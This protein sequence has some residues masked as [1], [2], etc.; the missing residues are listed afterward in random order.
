M[1]SGVNGELA[2]ADVDSAENVDV[3]EAMSDEVDPML[4]TRAADEDDCNSGTDETGVD[5]EATLFE[6]IVDGVD[7]A[8]SVDETA[9]GDETK[10][11]VADMGVEV[12]KVP[13]GVVKADGGVEV[14]VV[15]DERGAVVWIGEM[16]DE[17]EEE[18][19][20]ELVVEAAV[21]ELGGVKLTRDTGLPHRP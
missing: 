2:E 8:I 19:R 4:D 21:L 5:E 10:S 9:F 16:I 12:D 15:D 14:G 17:A 7:D 18:A 1:D 13:D 20:E 11:L 3:D 6:R